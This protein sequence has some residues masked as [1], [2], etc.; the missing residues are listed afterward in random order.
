MN[1][2][3][4]D[5]FNIDDRKYGSISAKIRILKPKLEERLEKY[6]N[7]LLKN[8]HYPFA[9]KEISMEGIFGQFSQNSLEIKTSKPYNRDKFLIFIKYFNSRILLFHTSLLM[10]LLSLDR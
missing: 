2:R 9:Y 8:K 6:K 5:T 10:S 1:N 7:S 4:F 3:N